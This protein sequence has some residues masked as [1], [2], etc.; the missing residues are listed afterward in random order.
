MGHLQRAGHS[1]SPLAI[2]ATISTRPYLILFL[3]FVVRR[4]ERTGG[5]IVPSVAL[6]LAPHEVY[7]VA[8]QDPSPPDLVMLSV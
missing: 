8:V 4:A 6:D 2:L 1:Q 5:M 7:S 3:P